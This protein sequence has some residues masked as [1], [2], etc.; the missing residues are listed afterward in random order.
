MDSRG[1][2]VTV[3]V[4]GASGLSIPLNGF[5]NI[6]WVTHPISTSPLSIPL[7][8]FLLWLALSRAGD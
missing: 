7:N 8:G 3:S 5:I 6:I 1:G 2:A 4:G